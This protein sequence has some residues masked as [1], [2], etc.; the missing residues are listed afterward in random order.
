MYRIREVDGHDDDVAETLADLHRLTFFN[1]ASIPKF[2]VIGGSRFSRPC[3]SPLPGSFR[4]L[5]PA[6]PD[7]FAASAY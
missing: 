4:P 3:R 2:R 6:M 7:I 5:M 1:G